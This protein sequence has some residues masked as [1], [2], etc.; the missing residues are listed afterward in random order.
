SS[1]L[2]LPPS[3]TIRQAAPFT[4][5][6][7]KTCS[8][9]PSPSL[10]PLLPCN[11]IKLW[12]QAEL[13][14]GSLSFAV[15]VVCVLCVCCVCVLCVVC[16]CCVC[17]CCVCVLCVVCCVCVLCVCGVCVVCVC[18]VCVSVCCVCVDCVGVCVVG[19]CALTS[20]CHTGWVVLVT[21][22][23]RLSWPWWVK[24]GKL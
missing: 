2:S 10:S 3:H 1:P 20:P 5:I 15:C 11:L 4:F 9:S 21:M 7:L 13:K 19:V 14:P 6:S 23:A 24:V 18:V 17:V 22:V 16:V 8:P 12:T